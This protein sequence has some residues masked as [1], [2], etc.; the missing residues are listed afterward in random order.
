M[1]RSHGVTHSHITKSLTLNHVTESRSHSTNDLLA[2]GLGNIN[3]KNHQMFIE[4]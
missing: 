1:S 2:N 4:F 3:A